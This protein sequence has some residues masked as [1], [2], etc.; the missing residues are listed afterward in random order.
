MDR[1]GPTPKYLGSNGRVGVEAQLVA[2]SASFIKLGHLIVSHWEVDDEVTAKLMTKIFLI[3]K[4]NP[5]LSHGEALQQ[6]TRAIIDN[7]ASDEEKSP[8]SL[9]PICSCGRTRKTSSVKQR[10]GLILI[11]VNDALSLSRPVRPTK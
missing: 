7:P 3:M 5:P 6:A 9:G 11:L 4:D 10:V 1:R 2:N 8:R